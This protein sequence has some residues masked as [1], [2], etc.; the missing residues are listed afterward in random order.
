MDWKDIA[1]RVAKLGLP[2]LGAAL[3]VPGGAAIGA[4]LANAIGSDATPDSVLKALTLDA[5][6]IEQARQFQLTHEATMLKLA[7]DSEVRQQEI[8]MEDR[9]DARGMQVATRSKT[10]TVLAVLI[11][12]GFF[13]VLWGMLSGNLQAGENQSLLILLGALSAAWGAVVNY[14]FGSSA[15]SSRKTEFLA[16]AEA[17]K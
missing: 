3:P 14:N 11:T 7:I 6:A 5:E 17:L 15:D 2:L 4:A 9:K 12:L 1:E 13:G 16:R 8:A 10:P